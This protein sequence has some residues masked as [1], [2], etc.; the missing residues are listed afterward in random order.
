[1]DSGG[2]V[3]DSTDMAVVGYDDISLATYNNPPLTTI[4]QN[5]H[6]AGKVLVDSVLGLI[7]GEQV[8]DTMLATE[9]V[10]RRSNGAEEA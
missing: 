5:I 7:N 10:V 1:M 2:R 8:P 4:R 6:W 9:L 3:V